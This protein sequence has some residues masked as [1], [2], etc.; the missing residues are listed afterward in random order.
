[1]SSRIGIRRKDDP[2]S[3]TYCDFDEIHGDDKE[4]IAKTNEGV[5]HMPAVRWDEID[6]FVV[7]N[8]VFVLK[9]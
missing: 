7:S 4:F 2:N 1:M 8:I 6:R 5:Q 9:E 3:M